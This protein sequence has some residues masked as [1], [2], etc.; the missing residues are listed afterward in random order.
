MKF[1]VQSENLARALSLCSRALAP[2]AS[3]PVL[4]NYL[5]EAQPARLKIA[6][7]NLEISATAYVAAEVA[8]P[9]AITLPARTLADWLGTLAAGPI[10]ATLNPR[11]AT[12]RLTAGRATAQIKGVSA[13][14]YPQLP[15]APASPDLT[16]D[17]ER[18]R[19]AA[20]RLV[21]AAATE[22]TR[23]VLRG[24]QFTLEGRTLTLAAAD[25]LR[26]SVCTLPVEASTTPLIDSTRPDWSYT[27][28]SL[29]LSCTPGMF[30]SVSSIE[31]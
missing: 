5:I 8:E 30:L 2:H 1:S 25:G 29:S 16:L 18:F 23:P 3:L 11:T 26:L 27:D 28:P 22:D 10:S 21:M 14:E 12:V 13:D 19:T 31:P 4:A 7:S 17:P 15:A 24:V 9:G 6:A 20:G